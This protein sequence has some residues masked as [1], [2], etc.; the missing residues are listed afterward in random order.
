MVNHRGH[1]NPSTTSSAAYFTGVCRSNSCL[2]SILTYFHVK[3]K[4]NKGN[5]AKKIT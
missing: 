4:E 2:G 5:I 1:K 3:M